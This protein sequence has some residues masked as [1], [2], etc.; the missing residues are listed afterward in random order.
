M[1]IIAIGR[2]YV[3]HAKE[4]NNQ[5]PE[6]P[7]FFIKPETA[8]LQKNKAFYHPEFSNDIHYEAEI[9]VKINKL[10]KYID[11]QFA[12]KYY[13]QIGIGIDFTARDLQSEQK[14]KGLPWEVAKA[15][16]HSAPISPLVDLKQFSNIQDIHF[17]LDINGKRVQNGHTADMLFSV[18]KIIAYVS[19]FITLKIGDLIF[20]GTPS[21][22]G[23]V[24]IGDR[25]TASIEGQNLLDFEVK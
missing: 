2:N 11:E 4:L 8:L 7:V 3:E 19:Q 14:A 6:K 16:D 20:T 13:D 1:K 5:V 21:G 18:D 12:H 23:K 9:F 25:L 10:G 15:F 22:V 24:N 17:T